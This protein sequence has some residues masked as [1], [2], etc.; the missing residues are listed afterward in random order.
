MHTYKAGCFIAEVVETFWDTPTLLTLCEI[1]KRFIYPLL[2]Q[3][4][5]DLPVVFDLTNPL[6]E[7]RRQLVAAA[8]EARQAE[9]SQH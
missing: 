7:T 2:F 1:H 9:R 8:E 3:H 6:A 4:C 5:R